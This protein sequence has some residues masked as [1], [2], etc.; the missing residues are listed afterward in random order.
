MPF[1]QRRS[2]TL[3]FFPSFLVV[4][5]ISPSFGVFF[6]GLRCTFFV[7]RLIG[8]AWDVCDLL[9]CI[10][11]DLRLW[12]PVVCSAVFFFGGFCSL[13]IHT[14]SVSHT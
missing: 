13:I 6:Q 14:K 1:A 9:S 12:L 5:D 2:R 10:F 3:H 11:C 7:L 4:Y 8:F